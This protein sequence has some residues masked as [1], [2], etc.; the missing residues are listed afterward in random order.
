[1]PIREWTDNVPAVYARSVM[2]LVQ[3]WHSIVDHL[4]QMATTTYLH[5]PT[6]T[7]VRALYAIKSLSA[8]QTS[9]TNNHT[10]YGGLLDDELLDF[11]QYL[12]QL[13]DFLMRIKV[14]VDHKVAKMAL[15]PIYKIRA[16]LGS[17]QTRGSSN[18]ALPPLNSRRRSSYTTSDND[19]EDGTTP[20]LQKIDSG[21]QETPQ[22]QNLEP[23]L[24]NHNVTSG[25][26]DISH[27]LHPAL[28]QDFP[29]WPDSNASSWPT[30]LPEF[31]LMTM[32]AVIPF[33]G[34]SFW[35]P[36]SNTIEPTFNNGW[37]TA[38]E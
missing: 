13:E 19:L 22:P 33:A 31:D 12:N 37:F 8:L 7:T 28:R 26:E 16:H 30:D 27:P 35:N 10:T 23:S 25:A 20:T 3:S 21:D 4:T 36:T 18:V 14:V 6:V 34:A 29:S 9:F 15:T 24:L 1:V 38:A 5:C 2:S 32:P 11:E 17:R